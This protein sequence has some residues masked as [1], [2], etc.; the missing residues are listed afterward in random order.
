MF[1]Y[2][3]SSVL[4]LLLVGCFHSN[5][6]MLHVSQIQIDSTINPVVVLGGGV[7][8][9]TAA[10]YLAQ[11]E[12][13]CVLLEG[14]KPGGALAQSDSVRNWPGVLK[15][16][17]AN[18]V[19][20][21]K[22]QVQANG[23]TI[24]AAALLNADFSSWPYQL[25]IKDNASGSVSTIKALSCIIATGT[26]PNYLKVPGEQIF[27]G[28]GVTN[29][30]V[31]DGPLY[32]DK[33]VAVVGGGDAAVAEVLY[34]S[35]IAKKVH[36]L[37]RRDVFRAKD[38][39]ALEQMKK[40][41]NLAVHHN[42]QVV[43]ITGGSTGVTGVELSTG[44]HLPLDGLFLAIG[45][46][47]NSAMFSK[48]LKRDKQGYIQLAHDQQ[49]NVPGVFAAG[50][51]CDAVYKQ[52]VTSAGAGCKAALQAQDFLTDVGFDPSSL[53][54]RRDDLSKQEVQ[55]G[56]SSTPKIQHDN[57]P[58]KGADK[59][60]SKSMVEVTSKTHLT[61]LI[62]SH[63]EGLIID[64]AAPL[65][66]SCQAMEP[67]MHKVM[68]T[69]GNRIAVVHADISRDEVDA[70]DIARLVGGKEITTMPTFIFVKEGKEVYRFEGEKSAR[71]VEA[72]VK[73]FLL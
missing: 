2:V 18:I 29:C 6:N 46:K 60:V 67:V 72:M 1:R 53:K 16:P 55:R 26:E 66:L 40:L 50:D 11:A 9:L 59:K 62:A 38:K 68:N 21:M 43:K 44:K 64:V 15:S 36:L 58:E 63:S 23:V 49:T 7:A 4:L 31:C 34:L 45:S 25:T 54:L 35:R 20:S 3:V 56:A 71:D 14:K 32:K 47:P 5:T 30:A 39:K 37:V 69:F 51:V 17:G 70:P 33:V 41:S 48:E 52:A 12:I 8:G 73:K 42:T 10:T 13:P 65:C 22:K 19:R 28:K 24:A 27:W 61:Q 57:Q